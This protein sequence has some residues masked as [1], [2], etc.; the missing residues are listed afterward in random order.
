[1]NTREQIAQAIR[2]YHA[3]L[4]DVAPSSDG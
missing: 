4:F 1:M 3:G 2:D